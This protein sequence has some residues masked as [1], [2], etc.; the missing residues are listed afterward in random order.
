[1]FDTAVAVGVYHKS[2]NTL[3][4]NPDEKT[5]F[6]PGDQIVALSNTSMYLP[7]CCVDTYYLQPKYSVLL[8]VHVTVL[9]MHDGCSSYWCMHC[10][11]KGNCQPGRCCVGVVAFRSLVALIDNRALPVQQCSQAD[12]RCRMLLARCTFDITALSGMKS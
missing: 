12:S 4:I 8:A 5:V 3:K 9:G 2:D 10:P 7:T 1:M 11:S 6:Q